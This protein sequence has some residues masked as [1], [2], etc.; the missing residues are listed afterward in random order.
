M[1]DWIL[2]KLGSV[3]GPKYIAATVRTVLAL[4]AGYLIKLGLPQTQVDNLLQALDPV[5]VG[6]ITV[7][8]T[9]VWSMI[10]K[11]NSTPK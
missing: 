3:F 2:E 9:W 7:G 10:Q 5:L 6:A 11:K 8:V 4:G 1:K